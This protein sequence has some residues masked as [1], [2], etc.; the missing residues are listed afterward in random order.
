MAA[1]GALTADRV[2]AKVGQPAIRFKLPMV[3]SATI[4][5]GSLV[6]IVTASGLAQASSD[7]AGEVFMGIAEEN[8][9]AAASGTT[10]ITVASCGIFRIP[11]SL[12]VAATHMGVKVYVISSSEVTNAAGGTNDI[13]VGIIVGIHSTGENGLVD[14]FLSPGGAVG[15]GGSA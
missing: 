2:V 13:P 12:T 4:Y 14:V 6:S 11:S 9:T 3:L 5:Q 7:S 1:L 8:K 15:A 10:Y